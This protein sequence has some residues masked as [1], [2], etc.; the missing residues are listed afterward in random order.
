LGLPSILCLLWHNSVACARAR[1]MSC[2]SESVRKNLE[3]SRLVW[4]VKNHYDFGKSFLF[5]KIFC[6]NFSNFFNGL[7]LFK[8][9][10]LMLLTYQK[11]VFKTSWYKIYTIRYLRKIKYFIIIILIIHHIKI[12]VYINC[13][14]YARDFMSCE[15]AM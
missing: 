9:I 3:Q 12:I 13:V 5:L 8:V 10:L 6:E 14:W 1:F 4:E 7:F 11:L 2:S 15:I